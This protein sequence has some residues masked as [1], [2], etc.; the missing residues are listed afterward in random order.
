M[1]LLALLQVLQQNNGPFIDP[2][3]PD[4]K[5]IAV[6]APQQWTLKKIPP[7]FDDDQIPNPDGSLDWIIRGKRIH[8]PRQDQGYSLDHLVAGRDGS[9]I[10]WGYADGD[11]MAF[12][13]GGTIPNP[14]HKK[15][16]ATKYK[17]GQMYIDARNKI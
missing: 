2:P 7:H 8:F 5:E 12:M 6:S 1:V 4:A 17:A 9:V 14:P 11:A 15:L 13:Q 3:I 10:Y 16:I